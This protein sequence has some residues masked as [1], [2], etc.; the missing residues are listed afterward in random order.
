MKKKHF[1]DYLVKLQKLHLRQADA[2]MAIGSI[3]TN[4]HVA[5]ADKK[6]LFNAVTE[7]EEELGKMIDW[8]TDDLKHEFRDEDEAQ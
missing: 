1:M 3:V 4:D 5:V 8:M 7:V 2:L 6:E